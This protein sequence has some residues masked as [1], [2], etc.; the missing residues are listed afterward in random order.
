MRKVT[1]E[2]SPKLNVDKVLGYSLLAA[3]LAMIMLSV[4]FMYAVFTGSM[5]PPP[6]FR[7]ASINFPMPVGEGER[8]EVELVQ[9]DQVSRVVNTVLWSF[10]MFFVASAGSKIGGLGVKLA[11]E[12]K[13]EVK[14]ED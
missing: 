5:L 13:V 8:V 7:M 11:R 6:I 4:Y 12:I 9:G 3:G 14:R 10:L 2:M 1:D